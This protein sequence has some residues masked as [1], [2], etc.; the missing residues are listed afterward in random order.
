MVFLRLYRRKQVGRN[1]M[2]GPS[3]GSISDLN[4][5]KSHFSDLHNADLKHDKIATCLLK[6]GDAQEGH[7]AKNQFGPSVQNCFR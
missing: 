7:D 5:F 4:A 6:K 1:S 3:F 2:F